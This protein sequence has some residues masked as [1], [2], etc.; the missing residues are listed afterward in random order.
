MANEIAVLGM[1]LAPD[2][3]LVICTITIVSLPSVK[4]K[5]Q[6]SGVYENGCQVSVSAIT[7]PSVGATIPDPGPYTAS[8]SATATKSKADSKLVLRVNDTTGTI[9]ATPQIPGPSPYPVNFKIKITNA[10][11]VKAHSL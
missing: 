8:F 4:T 2:N 1:T 3:P 6:G 7:V 10:G 11:Q 5:A 9:T